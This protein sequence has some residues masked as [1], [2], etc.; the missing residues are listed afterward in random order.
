[1]NRKA[2]DRRV[3][4]EI[5]DELA[6]ALGGPALTAIARSR[7]P[8]EA[9]TEET[10]DTVGEVF[11]RIFDQRGIVT[12]AAAANILMCVP[13]ILAKNFKAAERN[14]QLDAAMPQRKTP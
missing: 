6:K 7:I 5:A 13:R 4:E 11:G 3:A 2:R 9:L 1:M 14:R 8:S 10:R 12:E